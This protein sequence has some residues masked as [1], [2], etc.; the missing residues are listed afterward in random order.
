M[1]DEKALLEKLNAQKKKPKKKSKW[2]ARLE[3]MQKVQEQQRK[4]RR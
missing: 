3:Q 1:I 2:Q 4:S